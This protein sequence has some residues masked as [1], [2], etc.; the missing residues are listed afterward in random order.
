MHVGERLDVPRFA[1][2][3]LARAF[4]QQ[5]QPAQARREDGQQP[6]GLAEI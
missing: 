4:G 5:P 3:R 6:I 1:T 2:G